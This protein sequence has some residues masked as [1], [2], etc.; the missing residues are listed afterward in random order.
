MKLSDC[1]FLTICNFTPCI[2]VIASLGKASERGGGRGGGGAKYL[3]PGLVWEAR[4][5]DKAS[6]HCAT[7]K[8][9]GGP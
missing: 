1:L 3:G 6:G 8:R 7:V 4:N 2:F 9:V 5:F